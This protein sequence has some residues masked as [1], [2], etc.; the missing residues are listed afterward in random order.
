MGHRTQLG[1]DMAKKKTAVVAVKELLKLD[2]G[3][4]PNKQA[5]FHGVDTRQIPGVDTVFDLS[6][7]P[8][9]WEDNSVGQVH[10]SH[11]LEHLSGEE[12]V[13]FFNEL[14]RVMVK[15]AQATIVTP[16]WRSGRAYGDPTHK[17][18]PVVEMFW[19]YLDKNWRAGN[20]PHTGF[21]CDFFV[22]CVYTVAQPW[23]SRSY[24]AQAFALQH[25]SEV[26]MD[27]ISTVQARK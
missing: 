22:T 12:R 25:Y 7:A 13:G 20:A 1:E 8:W 2:L 17:W 23:I 10:C 19:Y 18:P 27:M 4:G 5:G 9:P 26:A 11:F 24:D 21:D 3:C 14:Y 6:K 15:D 16:H